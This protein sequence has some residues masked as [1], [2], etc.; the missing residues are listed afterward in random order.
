VSI[1]S[2]GIQPDT[3]N[4]TM[5]LVRDVLDFPCPMCRKC[6]FHRNGGHA[7][8]SSRPSSN[9]A[10]PCPEW[11]V[12]AQVSEVL[13][14]AD[15]WPDVPHQPCQFHDVREARRPM[16]D[17]DQQTRTAMRKTIQSNSGKHA[18]N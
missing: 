8:R 1:S 11:E 2:D 13:A 6:Q 15:L 16:Y 17:L 3:G 14:V 9:S 7:H 4:E 12:E 5:Y 10:S 18:P